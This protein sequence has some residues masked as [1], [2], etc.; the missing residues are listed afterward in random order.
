MIPP[1]FAHGFSVLSDYASV[2]Y[3]VDNLYNQECEKGIRFDD[4]EL[5]INWGVD[6]RNLIISEKDMILPFMKDIDFKSCKNA[7]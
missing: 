1:G 6:T 3:K 5:A 7:Q 4:S 2:L